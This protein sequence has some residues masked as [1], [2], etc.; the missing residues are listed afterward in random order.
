MVAKLEQN[1][2][3]LS[4]SEARQVSHLLIV[5]PDARASQGVPFADELDAALKRRRKKREELTKS[6]VA[7]DL[8]H[9]A[10]AAWLVLNPRQSAFEQHTAVRK[11]LLLLRSEIPKEIALA[12]YGD[13]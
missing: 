10:L 12:V 4:A 9:G 2:A 5:L 13:D 1:P 8:A 3:Q 7:T 6:P 11:A